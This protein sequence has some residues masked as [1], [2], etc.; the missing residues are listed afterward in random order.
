MTRVSD[1]A[2]HELTQF[3]IQNTQKRLLDAQIQISTGKVATHYSALGSDTT[4]LVSMESARARIDQY[5]NNIE[6]VDQR[7]QALETNTSMIFELASNFRTLLVNGLN[8]EASSDLALNATAQDLLAQVAGLLN[9]KQD[10]RYLF[11]GT[12]TNVAPVDLDAPAFGTPPPVYPGTADTGYFQG[13]STK[14]AVR[15]DDN[16]DVTYGVTADQAGFEQVIRAL[17]LAATAA[18]GP[19]QDRARLE[20]SLRV[21]NQALE[22]VPLIVSQIGR[23]RRTLDEVSATHNEFKLFTEEV[24]GEIENVDVAE[25][26]TRLT[27]DLVTLEASYAVIARLSGLSLVNFL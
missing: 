11:A 9:A 24:I 20:E 13:D 1:F 2:Q 14:L 25:A 27:A 23:A 4:R 12:A 7:L 8:V 17:K 21:I 6:I 18:V 3:H 5:L 22:S 10:G 16:L 15:V 19:P 26:I